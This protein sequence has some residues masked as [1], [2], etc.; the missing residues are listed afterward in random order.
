VI[1]PGDLVKHA[2]WE[3]SP[4][5]SY[6][7]GIGFVVRYDTN[8][9]PNHL[10]D[11]VLKNWVIVQWLPQHPNPDIYRAVYHVDSLVR[12]EDCSD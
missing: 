6:R 4:I 9:Q 3:Q 7:S 10:P 8:K 11:E 12:L 5:N 1:V 2:D